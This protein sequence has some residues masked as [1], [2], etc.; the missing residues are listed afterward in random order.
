[1][2]LAFNACENIPTGTGG[3]PDSASTLAKI[4]T[5]CIVPPYYP[6]KREP[7]AAYA[8][9][10]TRQCFCLAESAG[11]F[12]VTQHGD[13]VTQVLRRTEIGD[14]VAVTASLQ[15]YALDSL[16]ADVNQ[17][18]SKLYAHA[19]LRRDST[20]GFPDSFYV[21]PYINLADD[22]NGLTIT[23]FRDLTP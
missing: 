5:S 19:F 18:L 22:E 3:C 10:Y 17:Q 15:S 2:G 14:T 4:S 7:P 23:N 9:T 16:W 6:W 8:F 20:W 12:F 13:S 1:M 21:D 11:P